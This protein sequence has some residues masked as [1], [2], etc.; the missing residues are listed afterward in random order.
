M[1]F[2]VF[3][4]LLIVVAAILNIML[5]FKLWQMTN[6]VGRIFKFMLVRDGYE[7]RES[8]YQGVPVH[9]VKKDDD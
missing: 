6:N 5:F 8:V 9:F 7:V 1:D 3:T 2:I 4:Q